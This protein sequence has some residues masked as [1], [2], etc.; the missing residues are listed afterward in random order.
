MS[1][2][3]FPLGIWQEMRLDTFQKG[4]LGHSEASRAPGGVG[5]VVYT[6]S[7]RFVPESQTAPRHTGTH[8]KRDQMSGS[9]A[10]ES[11]TY[12]WLTMGLIVAGLQP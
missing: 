6:A 1:P 4:Y 10:V 3:L 12:K 2:G 11:G 9:G 7:F 8:Q 5:I